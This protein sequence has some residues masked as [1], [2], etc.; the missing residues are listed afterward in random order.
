MMNMNIMPV[1]YKKS[2]VF[3]E[4]SSKT[5]RPRELKLYEGA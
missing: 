1:Q 2:T 3:E 5:T 4:N